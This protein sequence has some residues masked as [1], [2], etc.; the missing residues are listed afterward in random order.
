MM[1]RRR[2]RSASALEGLYRESDENLEMRDR[3]DDTDDTEEAEAESSH[4]SETEADLSDGEGD[5]QPGTSAGLAPIRGRLSYLRSK[6]GHKWTTTAPEQSRRRLATQYA[7]AA[8][9]N[10]MN[11]KTPVEAWS[12]LFSDNILEIITTHNE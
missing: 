1:T 4:A 11:A 3:A 12:C 2:T 6:N 8:K 5:E 10:A 7:L 9:G